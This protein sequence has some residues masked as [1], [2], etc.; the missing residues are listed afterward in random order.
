MNNKQ[1][2][3]GQKQKGQTKQQEQEQEQEK[4]P[5]PVMDL[6]N[7]RAFKLFF[8]R[9]KEVLLSLLKTFLPLPDKKHIQN[10][11][12][13]SDKKAKK[14]AVIGHNEEKSL[15]QK[16]KSAQDLILKDSALYPYFYRRK[17]K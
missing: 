9:N 11:E 13:I 5:Y 12:I 3:Q 7:D 17:A 16:E 14:P 6:T 10:V 2:Q 4:Q 15:I 8:S 1:K